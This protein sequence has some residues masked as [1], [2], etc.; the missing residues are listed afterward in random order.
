MASLDVQAVEAEAAGVEG[1]AAA[2]EVAEVD[3]LGRGGE[4]VADARRVRLG[5]LDRDVV[6]VARWQPRSVGG[7]VGG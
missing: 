5:H 6:P 3:R 7:R 2:A 4:R 1:A